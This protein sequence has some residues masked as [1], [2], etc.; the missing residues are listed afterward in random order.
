MPELP[1]PK[2]KSPRDLGVNT[3]VEPT[4]DYL[5]QPTY[6]HLQDLLL[7]S[8]NK[9]FKDDNM[10][11]QSYLGEKQ[12]Y[13]GS[14]HK[15]SKY[16]SLKEKDP[17][18][19]E[20][21]ARIYGSYEIFLKTIE[22]QSKQKNLIDPRGDKKMD[23][24]VITDETYYKSDHISAQEIILEALNGICTIDYL[25]VR[26]GAQRLNGTLKKK[27][28]L[29]SQVAERY[30]FFGPLPGKFGEKVVLWNINKQKW[31]SFYVNFTFRF[32]KDDT[33]DLE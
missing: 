17:L 31:S 3:S 21:M 9:A 28:I 12:K 14:V 25:D 1:R 26:G 13:Q 27:Y 16:Q 20:Q 11:D 10:N 7:K 30:N 23:V 19:G 22:D 2:I 33:I 18:F 6:A 4:T 29:G 5:H 32:V 15:L 8:V 24:T